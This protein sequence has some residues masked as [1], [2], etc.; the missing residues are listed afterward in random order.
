MSRGGLEIFTRP[1]NSRLFTISCNHGCFGGVTQT[2]LV[3]CLLLSGLDRF[4]LVLSNSCRVLVVFKSWG[5]HRTFLIPCSAY[6]LIVQRRNPKGPHEPPISRRGTW[7]WSS[8]NRG[9][10]PPLSPTS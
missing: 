1:C 8:R 2:A 3:A 5:F 7:E 10:V 4:G 6:R 9:P